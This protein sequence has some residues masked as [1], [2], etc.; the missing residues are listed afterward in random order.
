M[1]RTAYTT[2]VSSIGSSKPDV[3]N[4]VTEGKVVSDSIPEGC[5][6]V[7]QQTV[8]SPSLMRFLYREG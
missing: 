8:N 1:Q 4:K 7:S 3:A 2:K 5:F 6:L